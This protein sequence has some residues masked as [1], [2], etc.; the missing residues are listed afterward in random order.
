MPDEQLQQQ[1]AQRDREL[2]DLRRQL[3]E[4]MA[5]LRTLVDVSARLNETLKLS[6]LL[7]LILETANKLL[8]AET[9]SLLLVDRESGDLIFEIATGDIGGEVERHRVPV[10]EGIAGWVVRHGQTLLVDDAP[11]DPRFYRDI[12]STTGFQTRNMLAIPLKTREATVGVIEVINKIGASRFSEKD[13]ELGEA[14]ANQAAVAIENARLYARLS[15]AVVVA[16][17]SY[18]L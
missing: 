11:N 8:N 17:M 1:L 3:D 14:L 5:R 12:D 10:G 7:R 2:T 4:E 6:D 13:R 18:R 16:R 9:S 15:E